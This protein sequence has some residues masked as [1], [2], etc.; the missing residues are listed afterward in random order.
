M[1]EILLRL[2]AVFAAAVLLST[3]TLV[4]SMFLLSHMMQEEGPGPRM[5]RRAFPRV[6]LLVVVVSA[7]S[8]VPGVGPFLTLIAWIPGLALALNIPGRAAFFLALVNWGV[9]LAV[10]L[11]L[12]NTKYCG[13][14]SESSHGLLIERLRGALGKDAVLTAPSELVV[15]EC[16]GYTIEKNR[17]D[18]VVFPSTAEQVALVVRVCND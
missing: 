7:L 9:N 18:V 2:L 8:L 6:A 17:P 13:L 12:V 16:D 15:Y 4:L 5:L 1:P 3:T 10:L 14:M 11:T